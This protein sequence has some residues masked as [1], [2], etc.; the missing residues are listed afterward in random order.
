MRNVNNVIII[1]AGIILMLVGAFGLP[2]QAGGDFDGFTAFATNK[3]KAIGWVISITGFLLIA[4]LFYFRHEES[5]RTVLG[6]F[7]GG[8]IAVA[9]II[10]AVLIGFPNLFMMYPALLGLAIFGVCMLEQL[11]GRDYKPDLR[12]G[13]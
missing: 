6:M 10:I 7:V 13:G 3:V 1:V 2:G 5:R 12:R 4:F 9:S 8:T 11:F